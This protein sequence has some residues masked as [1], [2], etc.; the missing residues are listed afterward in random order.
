MLPKSFVKAI[1]IRKS[2]R[3]TSHT[4]FQLFWKKLLQSATNR[5]GCM[6]FKLIIKKCDKNLF[7][8][9]RFYKVW[10]QFITN[11]DSYYEVKQNLLQSKVGIKKVWREGIKKF[12]QTKRSNRTKSSM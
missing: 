11:Y 7:Q 4:F 9:Y 8:C 6:N 10:Q 1:V 2:D 3:K 12:Q 5:E